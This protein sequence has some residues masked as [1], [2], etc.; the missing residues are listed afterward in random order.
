MIALAAFVGGV[1]AFESGDSDVARRLLQHAVRRSLSAGDVYETARAR[2]WLSRTLLALDEPSAAEQE[3]LSAVK[4]YGRS[5]RGWASGRG[6]R[7]WGRRRG[8]RPAV[9]PSRPSANR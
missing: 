6:G 9:H 5:P 3:A 8:T 1:I 4:L 2:L 7:R